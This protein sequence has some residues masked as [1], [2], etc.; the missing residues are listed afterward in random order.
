[1]R[2]AVAALLLACLAGC[3]SQDAGDLKR[4]AA[5]LGETAK[6]AATNATVA[7]KVNTALSLRKGIDMKGLHI[8]NTA[9][10]VTVGGHVRTPEEKRLV[11]DVVNNTRGVDKVVDQLRI[12]PPKAATEERK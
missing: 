9:G 7:A 1:M 6:R 8:E 5:Q 4:D 2:Y 11:L 10:T 3:N 12:E